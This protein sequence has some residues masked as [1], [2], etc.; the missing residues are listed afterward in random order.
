MSTIFPG[1]TLRALIVIFAADVSATGNLCR[2][3][4]ACAPPQG[5]P[6]TND[7]PVHHRGAHRL[8]S[9]ILSVFPEAKTAQTFQN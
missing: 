4:W 9:A 8:T 3:Q 5:G 1:R 2:V 7:E 6:S